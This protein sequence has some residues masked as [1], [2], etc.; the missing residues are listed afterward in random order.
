MWYAQS[1]ID[2]TSGTGWIAFW[3]WLDYILTLAGL[4]SD[5][6]CIIFWHWLHYILTL[7]M[8][9]IKLAFGFDNKPRIVAWLLE[10]KTTNISVFNK[11]CFLLFIF[12]VWIQLYDAFRNRDC[13]YNKITELS[14]QLLQVSKIFLR[15]SYIY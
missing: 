13:Q 2:W 1:F 14:K 6:G 3:H 4:H 5:T 9:Y 15:I 10:K 12:S 7:C 8:T 11:M